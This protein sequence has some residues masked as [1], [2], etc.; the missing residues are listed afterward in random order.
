[1]GESNPTALLRK[2]NQPLWPKL[3]KNSSV[4]KEHDAAYLSIYFDNS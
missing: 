4:K 1:M 3:R 2:L